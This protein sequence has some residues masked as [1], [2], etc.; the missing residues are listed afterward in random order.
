MKPLQDLTR[1]WNWLPAFRVV[2]ET[3]H[4]PTAA[5]TLHVTPSALSRT[6]RLLEEE[7]G[8]PLFERRGRRLVLLPVGGELLNAVRVAMRTV[9]EGVLTVQQSQYRGPLRVHAPAPLSGVLVL[10]AFQSLLHEYP[11]IEPVLQAY[12]ASSVNAGLLLGDLDL[13]IMDDP[14]PAEGIEMT[15]LTHMTHHVYC[16]AHHPLARVAPE[17][18]EEE[19]SRATFVA[20]TVLPNGETPDAWPPTR[21]REV[22]LRVSRMFVAIDAVLTGNYVAIFPDIVA[23][24]ASL[25]RLDASLDA[26]TSLFLLHRPHIE[27]NHSSR[28]E[29]LI[30]H[31]RAVVASMPQI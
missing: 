21:S 2:A 3:E 10:P 7:L 19:L 13:A 4:L 5:K 6:V 29:L 1:L 15:L 18:L 20:P 24:R 8:E 14:I 22:G 25:V 27:L 30:E 28:V 11:T 16:A 26:S 31:L 9:H 23:Q 12:P 17:N